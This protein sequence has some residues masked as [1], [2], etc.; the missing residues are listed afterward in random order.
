MKTYPKHLCHALPLFALILA[1]LL[2]SCAAPAADSSTQPSDAI[3]AEPTDVIISINDSYKND[4]IALQL[5]ARL[6]YSEDR[7][8]QEDKLV[9]HP[10]DEIELQLGYAN[11]SN[12]EH[13]TYVGFILPSA[14]EYQNETFTL[15]STELEGPV[16][17]K[18]DI[19]NVNIG[20]YPAAP[21]GTESD[22]PGGYAYCRI[23]VTVSEDAKPDA[24]LL[25]QVMLT[26]TGADDTIALDSASFTLKVEE[27]LD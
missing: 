5:K 18:G 8:W 14:L 21:E 9:V 7:S 23:L 10:G 26:C 27:I 19:S 20:T 11:Y 16:R 17:F 13:T 15:Y 1:L 2:S 25:P 22:T 4:R 3:S 24:T 12:T 6:R